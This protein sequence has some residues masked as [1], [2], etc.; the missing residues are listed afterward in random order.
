MV[1]LVPIGTTFVGGLETETLV[2]VLTTGLMVFGTPKPVWQSMLYECLYVLWVRVLSCGS[3]PP[4]NFFFQ[5]L[6][7]KKKFL[8]V[9][10]VIGQDTSLNSVEKHINT[11]IFFCSFFVRAN[12]STN[13]HFIQS[14]CWKLTDQKKHQKPMSNFS[15]DKNGTEEPTMTDG[16]PTDFWSRTPSPPGEVESAPSPC[17]GFRSTLPGGERARPEIAILRP[18]RRIL[19]ENL[20]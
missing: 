17:A 15:S 2:K 10:K 11:K 8:K 4:P 7:E 9:R 13:F 19:M 1:T 5:I 20:H 18:L 12:F 6:L 14:K 3:S 16:K